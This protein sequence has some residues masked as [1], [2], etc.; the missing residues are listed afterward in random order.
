ME[1]QKIYS[2]LKNSNPK[3]QRISYDYDLIEAKFFWHAI[4]QSLFEKVFIEKNTS[5]IWTEILRYLMGDE[6]SKIS[7]NKGLYI[8]GPTGTGKTSTFDI[9]TEFLKHT[10]VCYLIG[11]DVKLFRFTK[12]SSKQ[13]VTEFATSGH[14]GL[15]KYIEVRN[16]L[17]DDLGSEISTVKYYGTQVNVIEEII[18]ERYR[19]IGFTH[20]TSNLLM[21]DLELTYGSR[22]FS[23]LNEMCFE[24]KMNTEDIRL[25]K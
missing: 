10:K 5:I 13:I 4:A 3:L 11:T 6:E 18:E 2:E 7:L 14:E 24:I 20:I 12:V 25:K 9:I 8:Y 21:S 15:K 22:V 1:I 19:K 23:R 17:I 16:L